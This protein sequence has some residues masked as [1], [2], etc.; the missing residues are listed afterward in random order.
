MSELQQNIDKLQ[1][2]LELA[3]YRKGIVDSAALCR[4]KAEQVMIL[5][6][7]SRHERNAHLIDANALLDLA[8]SLVELPKP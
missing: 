3:I 4:L 8:Q 1:A 7:I 6:E 5:D 2:G